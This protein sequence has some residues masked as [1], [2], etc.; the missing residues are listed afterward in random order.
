MRFLVNGE[1]HASFLIHTHDIFRFFVP[2]TD[3]CDIF[4]V[5]RYRLRS[6]CLSRHRF[7]GAEG[8]ND[9]SNILDRSKLADTLDDII[10]AHLG[11][12]AACHI[13]VVVIDAGCE[14][15]RCNIVRFEEVIVRFDDDFLYLLPEEFYF[16]DALEA[17]E[18]VTDIGFSHPTEFVHVGD[19]LMG[20]SEK[21][22]RSGIGIELG[23]SQLIDIAVLRKSSQR[24]LQVEIC[25]VHVGIPGIFNG[26]LCGTY[27]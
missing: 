15:R 3:C 20:E 12:R 27:P 23:D 21:H 6:C 7:R 19:M 16:R 5:Y 22:N 8:D 18:F 24:L 10:R 1:T 2:E 14:C 25:L 13:T 4:Q 9:T 17:D 11:Q 26:N